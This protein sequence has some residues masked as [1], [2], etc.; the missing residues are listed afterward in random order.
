MKRL[1]DGEPARQSSERYDRQL[2]IWG[3]G[4]QARLQDASILILGCCATAGEALRNLVLPGVG[5]FMIVD[6]SRVQLSDLSENFLIP[7]DALDQFKS[8]AVCKRA[9]EL[10]PAVSGEAWAISPHQYLAGY[11]L[12]GRA[13]S[14][15]CD[16]ALLHFSY[17]ARRD[18]AERPRPP[19]ICSF[20]LVI[21]CLL[22]LEDE[23]ELLRICG[24]CE[25]ASPSSVEAAAVGDSQLQSLQKP[26]FGR[27]QSSRQVPVVFL[28]G[29]GFF[30]W[31]KLWAGEYCL[32]DSKPENS[33][34]DLRLANPFPELLKFAMSFDLETMDDE[35]HSHVPFIVILI[36]A[37]GLLILLRFVFFCGRHVQAVCR[38][39]G[40][41][42]EAA[43]KAASVGAVDSTF[44]FPLSGDAREK[45]QGI[46]REMQ[47]SSQEMNFSEALDN[48]YRA[49]KPTPH[50]PELAEIL[51][52]AAKKTDH[53]TL[54][55]R[56]CRALHNFVK[57]QKA[58]PVCP[59]TMD[60]TSDTRNYVALQRIYAEKA[61][62]DEQTLRAFLLEGYSTAR[63]ANGDDSLH[64]AALSHTFSLEELQCFSRNAANIRVIRYP[65]PRENQFGTASL[66]LLIA[67]VE[68]MKAGAD[69]TEECGRHHIPW[70]VA[71]LACKLA[72]DSLGRFPGSGSALVSPTQQE[73][74]SAE[75]NPASNKSLELP[76]DVEAVTREV[77]KIEEAVG[78][79]S[80]VCDEIIKQVVQ[81]RGS[82]FPT[83]AA[84]VG[85]V[86]AQ[87]AIK[88]LCLQFEPIN[89]TFLWNG[90]ER[91]GL[92]L[93]L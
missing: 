85:G 43:A 26:E 15:D 75:A 27:S 10:N 40:L 37:D 78:L 35:Q 4:G 54:F 53:P 44:C 12:P 20:D 11:A 58:L 3:E 69:D 83:T 38:Y 74:R 36:Q 71:A 82:E 24:A 30:G 33:R 22:P 34:V 57:S 41:T 76:T 87:E 63:T 90:T 8:H 7:P 2:R 29:L 91:R 6:D 64:I 77:R 93:E 31:V 67:A 68:Q 80:F 17:P 49:L 79:G 18:T 60:M 72:A 59:L 65:D 13:Q 32:V 73:Q 46:V 81:Y 1:G 47:R 86:A 50:S 62:Q 21:T 23:R 42:R 84:L 55:W 66:G 5:R 48:V 28:G 61:A 51:E 19:P 45:I 92:V 14:K 39:R 9:V 52:T 16:E 89:N 70:F 56:L 25:T 88:L